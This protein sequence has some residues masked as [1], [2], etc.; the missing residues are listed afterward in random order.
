MC[1]RDRRKIELDIRKVQKQLKRKV[2]ATYGIF[3]TPKFEY[4][5][6]K[7]DKQLMEKTRGIPELSLLDED[8]MTATFTLATNDEVDRLKRD[9]EALNE[10]IE[11]EELRVQ[12]QLSK[13]VGQFR[14]ML[15]EN[16]TAIGELDFNLA[17]ASWALDHSC[18]KPEITEEHVL[19]LVEGRQLV[20]CV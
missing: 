1:I 13:K 2:E 20:R 12:E 4:V 14:S 10:A 7:T 5:V 17:K 3:M 9:M 15:L 19:E 6:A 8:Y 16:C 18:V 11:E